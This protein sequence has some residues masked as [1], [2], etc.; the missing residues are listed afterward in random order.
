MDFDGGRLTL[1]ITQSGCV[2]CLVVRVGMF[3]FGAGLASTNVR[4]LEAIIMIGNEEDPTNKFP[5][6]KFCF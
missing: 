1:T 4:C 6:G 2:H 5:S 3:D